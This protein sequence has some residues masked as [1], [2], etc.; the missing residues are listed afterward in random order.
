MLL[1]CHTK[2][3][4]TTDSEQLLSLGFLLVLIWQD[5]A[6]KILARARD[7]PSTGHPQHGVFA[8]FLISNNRLLMYIQYVK[9]LYTDKV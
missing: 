8:V 4:V 3:G 5:T 6:I 1:L 2:L 7:T 9:L